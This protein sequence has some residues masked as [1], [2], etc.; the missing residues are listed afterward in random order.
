V[1]TL[2]QSGNVVF[3][4]GRK[5]GAALERLLE[6]ETEKALGVGVDFHV[7]TAAEWDAIIARNPFLAEAKRDPG[8]L[9]VMTF[10]DA[11]SA[12]NVN[13]LQAAIKGPEY[14]HFDGRQGY[15]VYPAGI[16]TSKLTSALM[17]RILSHRGTARNWNTVMKLAG[18]VVT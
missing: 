4:A 6:V 14:V 15:L 12:K 1:K 3:D 8:H 10:K 2:L 5:T 18:L 11:P 7:R 9:L 17:D 13:A 16:G